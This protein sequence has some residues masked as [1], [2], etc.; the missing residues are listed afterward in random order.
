MPK[1]IFIEHK[2]PKKLFADF[3]L[4]HHG[5][6]GEGIKQNENDWNYQ[7]YKGTNLGNDM[8]CKSEISYQEEKYGDLLNVNRI[9]NPNIFI[10]NID[11]L[12]VCK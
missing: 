11:R 9:I 6:W 10:T 4:G 3:S 5:R 8:L 1:T 2:K 7:G 12:L